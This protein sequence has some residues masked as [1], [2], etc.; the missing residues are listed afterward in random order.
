VGNLNEFA[1]AAFWSMIRRLDI[2]RPRCR[3]QG[4][5]NARGQSENGLQK[6]RE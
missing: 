6:M 2:M 4:E 3:G 5:V 1:R